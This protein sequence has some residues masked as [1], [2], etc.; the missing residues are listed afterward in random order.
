[1]HRK[2]PIISRVVLVILLIS[3]LSSLGLLRTARAQD[4]DVTLILGAYTTPGEAYREIIPLFQKYW[5]DKTG[6]KVVFQESYQGSGAQSRAIASGFEADI[7]A[8]SLEADIKR[9]VDAKLITHDWKANDYAGI[10]STSVVA[11]AVREGNP[12][13]INDWADLMQQGLEI[14]TPDPATSGGAQWNLLAALGAAK[15]GNV[16]GYDATEEG[17]LKFLGDV[18]KNVNVMDKGARESIVNFEKGIGDVAITYE[19]EILGGQATGVTYQAI[20]PS[21]TIIIETPVALVDAYVDKHGTREVAEAFYT[22][23]WTP[24][25]QAIFANHGF[26]PP[27]KKGAAGETPAATQS[28]AP[29]AGQG[30]KF[31]VVKDAFTI[32]YFGGWDK[33]GTEWFGQDG[34]ITKLL[35]EVKG[36]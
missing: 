17:A 36:K 19:N 31:P 7:A 15:R 8:L 16:K 29:D 33:A 21:S 18:F 1:M 22:F 34:K 14:L 26:R 2:L 13:N 24:E 32:D 27:T 20:Y 30:G 10:V 28:T 23:L 35:A 6:K 4:G 3:L 12:K 25:V 9:L 11:L 5:L